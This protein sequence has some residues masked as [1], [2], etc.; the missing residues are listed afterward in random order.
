MATLE[1]YDGQSPKPQ[2][3]GAIDVVAL[4]VRTS[5]Y[6]G[7]GHEANGTG[8]NGFARSEVIL[9][10]DTTHRRDHFSQAA[11]ADTSTPY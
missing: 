3:Y 5:V 7:V 10:A 4:I 11:C 8:G 1:V 2:A 9:A 6:H